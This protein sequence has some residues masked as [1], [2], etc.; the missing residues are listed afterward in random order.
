VAFLGKVRIKV[1]IKVKVKGGRTNASVPTRAT[2][3]VRVKGNV[4][5]VGQSLP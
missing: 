4:K 3:E 1:K 5:G 2:G